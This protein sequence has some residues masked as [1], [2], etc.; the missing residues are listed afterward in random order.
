MKIEE[1]ILQAHKLTRA[2]IKHNGAII[3][4]SKMPKQK[5]VAN[6]NR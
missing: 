4:Q 2:V 3:P 6:E 5:R 1:K